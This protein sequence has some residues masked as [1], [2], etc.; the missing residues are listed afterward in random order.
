[1]QTQIVIPTRDRAQL[2]QAAI[3]SVLD[4]GM[5]DL[6]VLVSD[7]STDAGERERLADFVARLPGDM[8]DY[9]T[10]P[11]PLAM[12]AHYEWAMKRALESASVT[13]VGYLPDRRAFRRGGLALLADVARRHP[14]RIVVYMHDEVIDHL[15]PVRI[16]Q[17]H[18]T[19]SL[20]ELDAQHL[21]DLAVVGE[22][23]LALPLMTNC[24]VPRGVVEAV[25][26]DFGSCFASTAPDYCFAF[27][28]LNVVDAVLYIDASCGVQYGFDRSHGFSQARGAKTQDRLQFIA[29]LGG[30]HL[31]VT[32]PLPHLD[33]A[34][35][36]VYNEY[37]FVQSEAAGAKPRPVTRSGY[38]AS[39]AASVTML[40]D[41][42]DRADA[43]QVLVAEGWRWRGSRGRAWLRRRSRLLS[44]FMRRPGTLL[45]RMAGLWQRTAVGR[46]F[47]R[48]AIARGATPPAGVWL[49]FETREA[50]LERARGRSP[51][52]ARDVSHVPILFEPPGGARILEACPAP[53]EALPRQLLDDARGGAGHDRAGLDVLEH[54]A[55]GSDDGARAHRHP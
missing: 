13:H 27:R 31:N 28:S 36:A 12:T 54:D 29:D 46:A 37:F 18:W 45:R 42:A 30:D 4:Q 33:V 2:A 40:D 16:L 5:D 48:L 23:P 50:A 15:R 53:E 6:A 44:F 21:L 24:L 9:V 17:H 3:E 7:N 14:D 26:R 49:A 51:R 8:V 11:R 34:M 1:L 55:V 52:R 32:T 43:L 25:Q 39:L 22:F 38:L 19:G 20:V 10:P 47:W 35:N 41:P